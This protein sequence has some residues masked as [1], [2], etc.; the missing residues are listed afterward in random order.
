MGDPLYWHQCTHGKTQSLIAILICY[1]VFQET[2]KEEG[3]ARNYV[4]DKNLLIAQLGPTGGKKGYG[5]ITGKYGNLAWQ[6]LKERRDQKI[7]LIFGQKSSDTRR[8]FLYFANVDLLTKY[9]NFF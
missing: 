5:T 8:K 4:K 1:F 6:V 9:N 3:W 2:E 7:S